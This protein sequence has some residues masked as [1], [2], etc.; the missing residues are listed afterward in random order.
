MSE[1][2]VERKR[3]RGLMGLNAS[4]ITIPSSA[5]MVQELNPDVDSW[6]VFTPDSIEHL[7]EGKTLFAFACRVGNSLTAADKQL[8][9]SMINLSSFENEQEDN[10]VPLIDPEDGNQQKNFTIIVTKTAY[11]LPNIPIEAFT[12]QLLIQPA[13]HTACQPGHPTIHKCDEPD[14]VRMTKTIIPIVFKITL[15]LKTSLLDLPAMEELGLIDGFPAEKGILMERTKRNKNTLD[16]T[17]K[18]KSVLLY[19][20]VPGGVL[21]RHTV[22]VYNTA[23]PSFGAPV[24]NNLGSFGSTEAFQTAQMTRYALPKLLAG[25]VVDKPYKDPSESTF[26]SLTSGWFS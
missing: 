9:G 21:I 10:N 6:N 25:E 4:K 20:Q 13:Y 18:V 22:C 16:A 17:R 23:I 2:K 8:I 7:N 3:V 11:L 19:N 24:I 14:T 5:V 12:P 26:S 1:K 15:Q